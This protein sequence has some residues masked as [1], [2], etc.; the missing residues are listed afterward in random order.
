[1]NDRKEPFRCEVC[2]V[3]A[4]STG[5]GESV[6]RFAPYDEKKAVLLCK[7]HFALVQKFV[8]DLVA[9]EIEQ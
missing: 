7:K 5:E 2:G 6:F 3:R 1:M 4:Y 9:G 8:R